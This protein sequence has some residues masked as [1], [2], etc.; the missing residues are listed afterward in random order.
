MKKRILAALTA[1]LVPAQA[2]ALGETWTPLI[3]ASAFDGPRIDMLTAVGGIITLL[4]IIAGIAFLAK[5]FR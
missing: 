5:I 1:L 3:T 4:L 2:F